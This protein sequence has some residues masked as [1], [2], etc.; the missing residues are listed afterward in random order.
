MLY[1]RFCFFITCIFLSQAFCDDDFLI[2][3]NSTYVAESVT[4]YD[5]SYQ[6][7]TK[8]SSNIPP[9]L[10]AKVGYFFFSNAKMRKIY[11]KGGWDV[12]LCGS[13]P[14]W[15]WLQLY[16]SVEFLERHGRSLQSHQKTSIWE[17]PLSLGLKSV[18]RI[19]PKI[20]Y[21]VTIG[22][23]FGFVHQQ[24]RSSFVDKHVN[25]SSWAG[26]LNTGFNFF[27][28]RHFLIDLCGEYSYQ[29]IHAHPS[30]SHV[31]AKRIQV[32]GFSFTAGLGYA[33]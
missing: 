2:E 31:S 32:G 29:R 4:P 1:R 20:H 10:E 9:L 22:P 5:Q 8:T 16:G 7:K 3:D 27:P 26:F 14:I 11:N 24:N 28:T 13:Y 33:F 25:R 15:K 6:L 21:Y 12:Q 17:V 23:R 18:I 30:K 19:I